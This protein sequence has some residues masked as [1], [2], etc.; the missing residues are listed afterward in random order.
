M[1][2]HSTGRPTSILRRTLIQPASSTSV[3]L[4]CH[5][6]PWLGGFSGPPR[7]L[8][9]CTCVIVGG[10]GSPPSG[11]LSF[12]AC[13]GEQIRLRGRSESRPGPGSAPRGMK[14]PLPTK[15]MIYGMSGAP[16][17][18]PCQVPLSHSFLDLDMGRHQPCRQV[19][20]LS[21]ADNDIVQLLPL[22]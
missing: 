14:L 16:K 7:L 20:I 4:P 19:Q 3:P 15:G 2:S 17:G 9:C 21:R 12:P 6:S 10:D 1:S 13:G 5:T 8:T 18:V 22:Q 11:P